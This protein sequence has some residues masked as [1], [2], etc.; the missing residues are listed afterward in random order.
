MD[1]DKLRKEASKSLR[2]YWLLI[3]VFI[4]IQISTCIYAISI[5]GDKNRQEIG[6]TIGCLFFLIIA[7][8]FV[9]IKLTVSYIIPL[10]K[11]VKFYE[12][13]DV[14][15]M[16]A[17]VVKV[18]WVRNTFYEVTVKN[19]TTEEIIIFDSTGKDLEMDKI[20]DIIY[21]KHS[22]IYEFTPVSFEQL[23]EDNRE[24][25]SKIDFNQ[26]D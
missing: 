12:H 18:K 9:E 16:R 17:V 15:R 21:L 11:D 25:A 24:K 14:E 3:V 13:N 10:Y 19:L 2:V 26:K 4:I 8:A 20:Y 5:L 23:T 7:I 22:K 6:G 1:E